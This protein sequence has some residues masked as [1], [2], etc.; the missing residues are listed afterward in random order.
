LTEG[1]LEFTHN[2]NFRINCEETDINGLIVYIVRGKYMKTHRILKLIA[3]ALYRKHHMTTISIFII[4]VGACF[5]PVSSSQKL[6]QHSEQ[7]LQIFSG[8]ILF[9]PMYSTTTYLLDDAGIVTH[10]WPS[11][12][13]PYLAAY[14]LD[15][16]TLLRTIKT[17]KATHGGIE[18]Y[19]TDGTVIWH[20]EYYLSNQYEANHDFK[21]LPNGHILMVV[22]ETK[23]RDEAIAA[24]R[25]PT[26]LQGD[27][28]TS[29]FLVEIEPTG[30][31]SG[32]IVWE[33]HVWDHLIQ[34][35][36]YSEEN[37]GVVT[38]HPELLDI[39]YG[40]IG[41][42]WLHCNSVAYNE[43]L[44]QILI[45]F[46]NLNEIWIIDHSTTTTEAAGHTGG[47]SGKG[48]DI[49]YRWGNPQ[50][51]NHQNA[52]CQKL[53][54]QHDASWINPGCP[55]EGHILV[56]NNG[57]GR[58]YSSVDEIIPPVNSTGQYYLQNG[59]TYGPENPAW[60]YTATPPISFY[61]DFI[62]G[63]QRLPDGNTLICD[64]PAGR[65]FEV[66]PDGTTIWQYINS[67]PTLL[68]NDVFKIQYILPQ[69]PQPQISDL[70]C[71]GSLSWTNIQ[72]GTPLQ[73]SFQVQNIGDPSSLLNWKVNMSSIAWGTWS[74]IP[75]SG[76]NLAPEDGQVTVQVS[77]VAPNEKNTEFEGY[78]RVENQ[79]NATDFAV[80]PVYLKTPTDTHTQQT[81]NLLWFFQFMQRHS[82]IKDYVFLKTFFRMILSSI[83]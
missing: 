76:E 41:Q 30:P 63:T 66:T 20:Y 34:N 49:L 51:Y 79:D 39:N 56:F 2:Y 38:E 21:P 33:W 71:Q 11:T 26:H 65:F 24:G 32:N 14:M 25:D 48:G 81:M 16:G 31:T 69:E 80:I 3:L 64:G 54:G 50:T 13:L 9:A 72:P 82:L 18:K 78:I 52:T 68:T 42:D 47:N 10:T 8:Q 67:Y 59:S 27:I 12:Y 19:S 28:L 53:F 5:V 44:D 23:T 22:S 6:Q 36:S 58:G 43:Q 4:L 1:G 55:G 61:A 73:G 70:D 35:Y 7:G 57:V 45:S 37:F 74:V 75:E 62:S 77:V 83:K 46:R 40:V 17:S 15:D 29:D 60:S